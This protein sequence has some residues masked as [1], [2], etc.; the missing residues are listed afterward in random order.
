MPYVKLDDLD[1][2]YEHC[3]AT[4]P[5]SATPIL[6]LSGMAS[7]SASWLPV[8]PALSQHYTL[9]LPD[10]R[11][12]GRSLPNGGS[13][14]RSLMVA[15]TLALLDALQ[16]DTVHIVGH[17]M[18]GMLAWALAAQY[19]ERVRSLISVAA[20][21][22]LIPARL[23]LFQSLLAV[24]DETNEAAWFELF[25]H[26][27]FCPS[28]F[29]QPLAVKAAVAAST[30]YPYK[31]NKAAFAQQVQGL[32]SFADSLML[33]AV[34]CPIHLIAG[35][36]DVLLSPQIMQDFASQHASLP[37]HIID[38]AAHAIHWEQ[39]EP[40]VDLLLSLLKSAE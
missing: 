31:Q 14:N 33:K 1:M 30:N 5:V 27:L 3:P 7:D 10:N 39:T 35:Q 13:C 17:S 4:K 6:M 25:Y 23:S 12:S 18:G 36:Q 34:S 32:A 20:I 21:P 38:N 26:F 15:D 28:F 37:V 19:P 40:F 16:I 8:T 2:Y 29:E 9:L 11:F 24:R 22:R